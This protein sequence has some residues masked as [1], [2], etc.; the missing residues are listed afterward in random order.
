[1]FG[2]LRDWLFNSSGKES[3]LDRDRDEH[4]AKKREAEQDLEKLRDRRGSLKQALE[5]KEAAYKEAESAGDDERAKDLLRDAEEI[6]KE[7]KTV[8]GRIDETSKQRNLA[9]NM[10]NL[11]EISQSRGDAYWNQLREMDRTE[12][13]EMFQQREMETEELH[14]ALSQTDTLSSNALDTFSEGAEQLHSTSEL[15]EEWSEESNEID[16]ESVFEDIETDDE[17]L[18]DDVT[19]DENVNL[20]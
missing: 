15:E 18:R 9:S 1:M 13:I 10:A 5:E 19:E 4:L 16:P 3:L 6:K 11:Q 20:S 14:Q 12:L 8:R 7:L 2:R 17:E